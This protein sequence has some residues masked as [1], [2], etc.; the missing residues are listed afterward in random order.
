[1]RFGKIVRFSQRRAVVSLDLFNVLN[2]DTISNASSAYN[3]SWLAPQAVVA[4]R[5]AKVSL[6]FDF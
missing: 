3:T 4:P 6:T 5:L 2:S 1:M